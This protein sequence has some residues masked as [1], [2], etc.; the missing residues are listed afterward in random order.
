[1]N[2]KNNAR[3]MG[4]LFS[5][6]ARAKYPNAIDDEHLD[7][8][9]TVFP[10]GDATPHDAE[11]TE[12]VI[13]EHTENGEKQTLMLS[14]HRVSSSTGDYW[15]FFA[16]FIENTVEPTNQGFYAIGVAPWTESR[17]SPAEQALFA[18]ADSFD[19]AASVPPG[20]FNSK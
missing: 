18:W 7:P 11:Q 3:W 20:V 14:T 1:M 4:W 6:Y 10:D 12:P 13:R 17:D 8:L 5:D 19:V 16:Y 15:V 9:Y 2:K